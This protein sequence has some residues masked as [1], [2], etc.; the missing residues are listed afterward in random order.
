MDVWTLGEKWKKAK[1]E[2]EDLR[3]RIDHIE[4][5]LSELTK[6]KDEAVQGKKDK[7]PSI[8]TRR[9]AAKKS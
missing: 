8:R 1:A 3:S 5:Y 2:I 4:S 9:R 6:V 7:S